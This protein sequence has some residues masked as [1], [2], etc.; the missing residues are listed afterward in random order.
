MYYCYTR[1]SSSLLQSV[2]VS[3][4]IK[5]PKS[6]KIISCNEMLQ[7]SGGVVKSEI[8]LNYFAS[9]FNNP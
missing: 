1:N 8:A 5:G 9:V 3:Y 2:M 4:L 7:V 6:T